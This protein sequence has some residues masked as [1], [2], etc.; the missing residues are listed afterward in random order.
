VAFDSV[1][2]LISGLETASYGERAWQ[3]PGHPRVQQRPVQ[4]LADRL[5]GIELHGT[6]EVVL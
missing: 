6:E 4:T 1:D 3:M 2:Q 5:I